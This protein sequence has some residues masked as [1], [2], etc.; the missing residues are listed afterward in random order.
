MSIKH[1]LIHK[2]VCIEFKIHQPS[3]TRSDVKRGAYDILKYE[4]FFTFSNDN[5]IHKT[6]SHTDNMGITKQFNRQSKSDSVYCPS[7]LF[8]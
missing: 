8:N 1:H 4:E 5:A 6:N 2:E 3:N 7:S